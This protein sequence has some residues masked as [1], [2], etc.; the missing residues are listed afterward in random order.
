[1]PI[2]LLIRGICCLRPGTAGHLGKHS[3]AQHRRSVPG[4]QPDPGVRRGLE[5]SRC[6][7]SSADW[8]PRNFERRVEVMFPVEAEDMRRRIVEE[9]IP[10][11]LSDNART[12]MLQPDGTLHAAGGRQTAPPHR[13]QVEL[14]AHGGVSRRR[15]GR[16][17]P[18]P[19][20]RSMPLHGPGRNRRRSRRAIGRSGRRRRA[21]RRSRR[22][23]CRPSFSRSAARWRTA[24]GRDWRA[25]SGPAAA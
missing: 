22:G 9:I 17:R 25:T 19:A 6:F 4:A 11:Y 2:D 14:L 5:S 23:H 16:R 21:R 3:R 12:R 18:K 20:R 10:T 13:S 15:L 7:S 1:M 24:R 8:M